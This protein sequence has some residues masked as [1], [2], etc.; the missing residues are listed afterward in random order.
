M[1]K[2]KQITEEISKMLDK[3][4]G[5]VV[6]TTSF[7][8]ED[9]GITDIILKNNLNV[10]IISL[11]TGRLFN[12]THLVWQKT[13]D[14]YKCKI[15]IFYPQRKELEKLLSDKGPF[16]FYESKENRLEC[17]NIRKIEP[18]TRALKD[19]NVWIT[20]IRAEQTDN[21]KDMQKT[22]RD[23]KYNIL[24]YNPL[25]DWTLNEVETYLKTNN[26]P[27]NSLHHKNYVS[28]GCQPCTRAIKQG[29]SFRDGRWWWENNSSK[30][31]GLHTK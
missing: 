4:P 5:K 23:E 25:L 6:F 16:S 3:N 31:C 26:V 15:E 7:G 11:D 10:R 30:E 20:G 27:Y 24:K 8:I 13:I 9:Q 21:R 17:C 19:N 1:E 12:E 2:I 28:I 22:E 14:K 18:L 29:E